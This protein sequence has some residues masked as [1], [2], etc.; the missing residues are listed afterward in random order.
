MLRRTL[1]VSPAWAVVAIAFE[2]LSILAYILLLS[3]VAGRASA[4]I[5]TRESAQ[6]TLAGTAATR[7]L[8]TAGAGGAALTVWTLRRSG[9]S[10]GGATRTLL[11]FLVLLYS[12]FLASI[13][14]AGAL[15]TL[16]VVRADGPTALSAGPAA[17]AALA[18]AVGL[19]LASRRRADRPARPRVPDSRASRGR[20]A[21]AW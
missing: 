14:A 15:I 13:V 20:R 16:G 10:A 7:L 21:R 19:A 18:I 2:C 1:S 8:P 11:A 5:G 9:L 12:V 4:R 3:L 17:A 6:I